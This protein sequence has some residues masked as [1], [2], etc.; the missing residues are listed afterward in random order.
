MCKIT[1]EL[2]FLWSTCA[3]CE[4]DGAQQNPLHARTLTRQ[5]FRSKQSQISLG[6]YEEIIL[7]KCLTPST[8][9]LSR[10]EIFDKEVLKELA[11]ELGL[12]FVDSSKKPSS[13]S[14]AKAGKDENKG[15]EW[16][17]NDW[18]KKEGYG[19]SK[20]ND[21][22][23]RDKQWKKEETPY[24]AGNPK[25]DSEWGQTSQERCRFGGIDVRYRPGPGGEPVPV[26]THLLLRCNKMHDEG[27][28]RF[29]HSKRD[30]EYCSST[31][32]KEA[33]LPQREQLV[34]K[35]GYNLDDLRKNSLERFHK[36]AR[37]DSKTDKKDGDD[38][39][40][41]A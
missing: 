28:C 20:G 16:K 34:K 38:T 35:L 13:T 39:K 5:E 4:I 17:G 2:L 23:S 36:T 21:W 11:V 6:L 15:N 14:S 41:A 9:A 7:E 25:I 32:Y 40:S 37:L 3:A 12:N 1:A 27:K 18:G 24:S 10:T 22:S 30:R 19:P 33:R 8:I 26:E 31:E 29:A